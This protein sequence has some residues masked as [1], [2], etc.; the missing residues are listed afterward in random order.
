M[1]KMKKICPRCSNED[2]N[3]FYEGSKGWYCRACIKFS[4]RLLS[5]IHYENW[6]DFPSDLSADVH[7]DFELTD[8]QKDISKRIPE[9]METGDVLVWAVTGAGKTELCMDFISQCLKQRKRIA[10]V[11][12]RRQVVLELTERFKRSF[13]CNVTALCEGYTDDLSGDLIVCTAHQC[14]RFFD[15]KFDHIIVDEPDA[16][17]YYGNAVL[18]GIVRNSCKGNM[19]YLTATSDSELLENCQVL[20]LFSRPHGYDLPV[21]VIKKTGKIA[22]VFYLLKWCMKRQKERIPFL[23]FVP[24]IEMANRISGLFKM[25]LNVECCT[26]KTEKKDEII[27]KMKKKELSGLICTT[28][29]ERGITFEGVDVCVFH[30]DHHVF[31][32]A[33]LIQIAGRVGRKPSRPTGDCLFLTFYQSDEVI[34][35][36]RMIEYANQQKMSV[37]PEST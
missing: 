12:A 1:K 14:Y 19:L 21:P 36:V 15:K 16:F 10:V 35:S 18:Q 7:L 2:Q 34:E 20:R 30:A 25:M 26:S 29:L 22:G 3:L 8:L 4:R 17:P 11:I 31:T 24:E 33:S 9:K 32:S 23:V 28:V 37:L 5:E 6:D 13:H 27:E